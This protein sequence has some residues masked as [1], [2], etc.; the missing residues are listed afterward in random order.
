MLNNN[1]ENKAGC[2][3]GVHGK[4]FEILLIILSIFATIILVTNLI[5]TKWY[6]KQSHYL[7]Y[8]EI[9]LISLNGLCFLLTIILRYWRSNGS[10]LTANYS[11][12]LC[13]STFIIILIILNLLGSIAE[14]I[15]FYFV[16][17]IITFDNKNKN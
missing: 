17:Y 3:G 9:G 11:A 14:E 12:A 4:N 7:Y 5:L 2:C 6:L 8:I 15:L 13:L 10:V 1:S 16:Y